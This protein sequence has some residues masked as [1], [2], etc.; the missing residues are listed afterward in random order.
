MDGR[1]T[2]LLT[3]LGRFQVGGEGASLLSHRP[4]T[5]AA[6]VAERTGFTFALAKSLSADAAPAAATLAAMRALDPDNLRERLVG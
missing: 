1:P 4:W 5:T 6:Q 3:D 2:P